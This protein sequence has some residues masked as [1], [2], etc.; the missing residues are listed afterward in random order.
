MIS[1]LKLNAE[2]TEAFISLGFSREKLPPFR[3]N[4]FSQKTAKNV[5]HRRRVVIVGKPQLQRY[6]LGRCYLVAPYFNWHAP[7]LPSLKTIQ[8]NLHIV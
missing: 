3:L 4:S 1:L 2:L 6:R 5:I 7:L 8:E